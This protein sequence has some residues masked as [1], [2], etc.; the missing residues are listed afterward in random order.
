MAT[1]LF[2]RQEVLLSHPIP[3]IFRLVHPS[4]YI[5]LFVCALYFLLCLVV[6]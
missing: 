3:G 4:V 6:V 1:D 5:V 2:G